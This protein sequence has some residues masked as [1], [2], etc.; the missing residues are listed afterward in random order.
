MQNTERQKFEENWKTAFDGAE[1][2]PSDNVWK[3]I[4]LDLAGQESATMKKRV[5]FYQ[6]LAA[7]TVIFALLTGAY[8]FFNGQ[9]PDTTQTK[10]TASNTIEN[11]AESKGQSNQS[12]T[13]EPATEAPG[14]TTGADAPQIAL[15][16]KQRQ[17]T[18]I[19]KAATVQP[20]EE[21]IAAVHETVHETVI[22]NESQGAALAQSPGETIDEKKEEVVASPILQTAPLTASLEEQKAPEEIVEKKSR[23]EHTWVALGAAAGNYSPN[24]GGGNGLEAADQNSYTAGPP[25][26]SAPS[27][28]QPRVGTSYTV[29]MAFGK[30]IGRLVIQSGVNLGKQQID[31]VSTYDT[32]TSS[33]TAKA[34]AAMYGL[35]SGTFSTAPYTVNSSMDVVSI[36]VQAGYMI[37]DRRLGWQMNAGFSPDFFLRNTLVDKSGQRQKFSQGAGEESPYRSVNWS[38]L[39]NTELSYRIGTHYRVSFVPGM[40]YS[41]TS[42]LKDDKTSKPLIL[43]V[44]FR[45]R[46]MFD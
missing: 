29:G 40:R 2:T 27:A 10:Q 22:G 17:T 11:K 30:K 3:S 19:Q 37:V 1:I 18:D 39:V 8:A 33:N 9:N 12:V 45:F 36:P 5:V 16:Q 38:G 35:S 42:I 24:M 25:L 43:D 15:V 28:E 46:Y 6:R 4:E 44:G 14:A 31:Y 26:A 7:A 41:F 32:R 13:K 23:A 20:T 34:S 21:S